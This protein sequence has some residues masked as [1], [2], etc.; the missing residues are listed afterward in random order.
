LTTSVVRLSVLTFAHAEDG[1]G[2]PQHSEFEILVRVNP[3]RID[4]E[5]LGHR[6]DSCLR[7]A[8]WS[9]ASGGGSI[10]R[11]RTITGRVTMVVTATLADR[12]RSAES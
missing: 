4:D 12:Q 1:L 10:E 8:V 2:I 6:A 7:Y 3:M 9:L 11:P 5:S